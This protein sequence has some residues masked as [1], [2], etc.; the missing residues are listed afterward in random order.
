MDEQTLKLYYARLLSKIDRNSLKCEVSKLVTTCEYFHI[1][2]SYYY[3]AD[4]EKS[5]LFFEKGLEE[6]NPSSLDCLL[7]LTKLYIS[8]IKL[9]NTSKE[10]E[11]KGRLL[12]LFDTIID[13][14]SSQVHVYLSQYNVYL[15]MLRLLN[16]TE[17]AISLFEKIFNSMNELGSCEFYHHAAINTLYVTNNLLKQKKY[18]KVVEHASNILQ[19]ID[20][21]NHQDYLSFCLSKNKALYL[22]GRLPEAQDNFL[23]MMN[24]LVQKNLTETYSEI[25]DDVCYYLLRSRNFDYFFECYYA[26][27]IDSFNLG[28]HRL[29]YITFVTM[30]DLYLEDPSPAIVRDLPVENYPS[31]IKLSKETSPSNNNLKGRSLTRVIPTSYFRVMTDAPSF[32]KYFFT[33]LINYNVFRFLVNI[34]SIFSRLFILYYLCRIFLCCIRI[35]LNICYMLLYFIFFFVLAYCYTNIF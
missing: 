7:H 21:S 34:F 22:L 23:N 15:I 16:E 18:E 8:Y 27:M 32:F 6:N 1:A 24:Y 20:V 10:A 14:P 12:D 3:L 4:Y 25:Y 9:G 26:T 17:K 5:A 2:S 28:V 31:V 29:A 33:S 11:V 19:C 30:Y 35:S 13:Q